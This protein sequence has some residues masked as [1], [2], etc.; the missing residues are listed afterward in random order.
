MSELREQQ[1]R[2]GNSRC[3][4]GTADVLGGHFSRLLST[5]IWFRGAPKAHECAQGSAF[6]T[7]EHTGAHWS[8]LITLSIL[9]TLYGT[10]IA[11]SG[12]AER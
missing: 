8:I 12:K 9:S 7:P 2:S 1:M 6:L 3:A 4:L 11:F 10:R 5:P